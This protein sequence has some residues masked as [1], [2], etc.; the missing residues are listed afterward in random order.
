MF[1]SR[2]HWGIEQLSNLLG[3]MQ[4]E[5]VSSPIH[6]HPR[7]SSRNPVTDHL[8][9]Q[10]LGHF[11][12]F[13]DWLKTLWINVSISNIWFYC[14]LLLLSRHVYFLF[15]D[16]GKYIMIVTDSPLPFNEDPQTVMNE[17]DSN[18]RYW[19][20]SFFYRFT[21]LF[22]AVYILRRQKWYHACPVKAIKLL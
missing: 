3:I 6:S 5:P 8:S 19:V 13:V 21:A 15:I 14:S 22:K 17:Y 16:A 18:K 9:S 12:F 7:I 1:Y 4:V 20:Y 11:E 2:D 10:N